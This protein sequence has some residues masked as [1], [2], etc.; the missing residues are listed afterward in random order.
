MK[1]PVPIL[2][3]SGAYLARSSCVHIPI[4][5]APRLFPAAAAAVIIT[6]T[7][8][9]YLVDFLKQLA[10]HLRALR[11]GLLV[12]HRK[13]FDM[14][15]HRGDNLIGV[16]GSDVI[17][18]DYGSLC[19][20]YPIIHKVALQAITCNAVLN[21]LAKVT[22]IFQGVVDYKEAAD[23]LEAILGKL[24]QVLGHAR[25]RA[26]VTELLRPLVKSAVMACYA[27]LSARY[28]DRPSRIP[29]TLSPRIKSFT[30]AFDRLPVEHAVD[31]HFHLRA[32]SHS[33]LAGP[34]SATSL[35]QSTAPS[36]DAHPHTDVA[37]DARSR[38]TKRGRDDDPIAD[39]GA[40]EEG[41][42]EH[43][44]LLS[45]NAVLQTQPHRKKR[46]FGA[47]PGNKE[48]EPL[49]AV[50]PV[51]ATVQTPVTSRASHDP[52]CRALQA[53]PP[54][55]IVFNLPCATDSVYPAAIDESV[56]ENLVH[57]IL[58]AAFT[59]DWADEGMS[60]HAAKEAV[61]AMISTETVE[62]IA[63]ILDIRGTFFRMVARASR[64]HPLKVVRQAVLAIYV[65]VLPVALGIARPFYV[66][67]QPHSLEHTRKHLVDVLRLREAGHVHQP[68]VHPM[69]A[70]LATN[71]FTI[72]H[73]FDRRF[74]RILRLL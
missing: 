51:N 2:K 30:L 9:L 41:M 46:K 61:E 17:L 69:H 3:R 58:M 64:E 66:Y 39:A 4:T 45:S 38:G 72:E 35:E 32:K 62:Y 67:F 43:S 59:D 8:E 22:N 71:R 18:A 34:S 6:A 25:A 36:S 28:A 33:R 49:A 73:I 24:D 60:S 68:N 70:V 19:C 15:E 23:L 48:N 63:R 20:K 54:G 27:Q 11:D 56:G 42:D 12:G 40:E 37:L 52:I 50:P 47:S 10:R 16:V 13:I 53:L 44:Q 31:R 7:T 5:E 65:H 14:Y 74:L 1:A 26:L 57:Y 21:A 55:A 29:P